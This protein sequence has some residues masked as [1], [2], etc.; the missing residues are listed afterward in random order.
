M[1]I[2]ELL[3]KSLILLVLFLGVLRVVVSN[4]IS[5]SGVKLGKINEEITFY[6]LENDNLSE[7]VFSMSSLSQ[8]ASEAA[9][10]GFVDNKENFVLTNSLPIAA[11][12]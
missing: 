7:K 11:R 1:K 9:K 8:I 6:K 2:Y 10:L 12:Q 5:T 3:I 4:S